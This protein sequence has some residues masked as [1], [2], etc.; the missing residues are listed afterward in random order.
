[1]RKRH[2]LGWGGVSC[3]RV[4]RRGTWSPSSL[5]WKSQLPKL[6]SLHFPPPLPTPL[7]LGT[8]LSANSAAV[9]RGELF[10]VILVSHLPHQRP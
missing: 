6:Q 4:C 5:G 8:S 9:Q 2:W 10:G 3:G 7:I 1:M